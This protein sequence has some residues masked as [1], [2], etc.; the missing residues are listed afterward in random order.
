MATEFNPAGLILMSPHLSIGKVAQVQYP[1]FPAELLTTD[2]FEN[3]KKISRVTCPLLIGHGER[4]VVIPFA[5]GNAL[6]ELAN[7][8]KA[9][10]AY[11][12]AGHNEVLAQGFFQGYFRLAGPVA[13]AVTGMPSL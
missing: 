7:Q 4:D 10:H 5:Q 2:R 11:P 3:F 1:M 13:G 6:F 12:E 9:F 8:P